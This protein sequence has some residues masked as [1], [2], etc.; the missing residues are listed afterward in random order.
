MKQVVISQ[1]I[2][3]DAVE[4]TC[5]IGRLIMHPKWQNRGIGTRLITEIEIMHRDTARFELFTGSQSSGNL[6][7]YHKMGYQEFRREPLNSQV[8]LA[9]LEKIAI[10][11][12]M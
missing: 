8:E 5:H 1:A 2:L 10:D 3:E 11:R 4:T 12:R 9:Y 6:H 7:L